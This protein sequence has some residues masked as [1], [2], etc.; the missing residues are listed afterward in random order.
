[1]RFLLMWLHESGFRPKTAIDVGAYAGDWTRDCRKVFSDVEI[2]MIEASP[3]RAEAL[4]ALCAT[5]RG[6]GVAQA[7]LASSNGSALFREQETNSGIA[8]P[9]EPG[10]SSMPTTTLDSLVSGTPFARPDLLKID[11]QGH[12]LD[13]LKGG[14]RTLATA[15]VVIVE[16]SLIPLSAAAGTF[17]S[18]IDW[19]D[20]HG[21]RLLDFGGFIRR[22]VDD[23]LWQVDAAFARVDSPL[24]SVAAGW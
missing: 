6:L 3:S 8:A 18:A 9:G 10:T 5:E 23:A 1:M 22:P 2:L 15:E 12:D 11:V 14:T 13:V 7:L 20:D 21:F 19:L 17:R 16:L 24:G 4:R